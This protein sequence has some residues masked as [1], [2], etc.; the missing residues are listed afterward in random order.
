[1]DELTVP[2]QARRLFELGCGNDSVAYELTR[3]SWD[4]TSVNPSAEGIQQARAAH[5][6]LKLDRD[7]A[8]DDL[9][10]QHG[11]FPVVLSV[12]VMKHVYAPRRY[13]RTVFELRDTGGTAIIS[14][15]IHG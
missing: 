5:P 11:Q 15:P 13:A 10:V 6:K 8:Y 14:A 4:I 9:A 1:M 7:S 3:R 12:E 2:I